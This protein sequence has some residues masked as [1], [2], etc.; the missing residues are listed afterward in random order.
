L[1]NILSD[2][3]NLECRICKRRDEPLGQMSRQTFSPIIG[4]LRLFSPVP[5]VIFG[6]VGEP[7]AYPDIVEIV[8]RA[9]AL[10]APVELIAKGG[11]YQ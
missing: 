9:K 3:C 1:K 7:L 10:G 6:G 2:C 11:S 4:G 5:N 8:V